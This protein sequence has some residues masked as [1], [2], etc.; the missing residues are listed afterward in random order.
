MKTIHIDRSI[1]DFLASKAAVPDEALASI[2]RR[3]LQVPEPEEAI[4]IDDES[5]NFLLS[6]AVNLGESPSVILRRILHLDDDG[7]PIPPGLVTFH[8][9]AGTGTQAWNAVKTALQAKV[10]DTFRLVN[11]DAVPH[12]LHT[13]GAPFL[14]P[15]NDIPPGQS[16]DFVL[17]RAFR[18]EPL[19]DHAAGL[20]AQFF[21]TVLA[22]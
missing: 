5:Y 9:P 20:N 6:K 13:N 3:E 1:H 21:I 15:A 19:F 17:E 11:D 4:E 7:G 10:G 2:L 16:A 8:I 18:G 14:H 12:R 22:L